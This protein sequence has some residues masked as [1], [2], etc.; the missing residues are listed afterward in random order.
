MNE[1]K[2]QDPWDGLDCGGEL[3]ESLVGL[4]GAIDGMAELVDKVCAELTPVLREE[5]GLAK[6][7]EASPASTV[8]FVRCV[9]ALRDR[10]IVVRD[11][12]SDTVTRLGV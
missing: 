11:R 10:V 7:R 6:D 3:G 5:P 9:H 8:P 4:R 2:Q 12:L 1:V